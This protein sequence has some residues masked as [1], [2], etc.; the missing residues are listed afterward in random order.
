MCC[1]LKLGG[2]GLLISLLLGPCCPQNP[3]VQVTLAVAPTTIVELGGTATITATLSAAHNEDLTLHLEGQQTPPAAGPGY[4]LSTADI[5]VPA[6]QTSGTATVTGGTFPDNVVSLSVVFTITKISSPRCSWDVNIPANA[7]TIIHRGSLQ[8]TL[9]PAPAVADGAQWRVDG[10]AWQDSDAIVRHLTAGAHTVDYKALVDWVEPPSESVTITDGVLTQITRTYTPTLTVLIAPQ[11]AITGGAQWFLT[12]GPPG[13]DASNHNSGDAI[14]AP[15]GNYNVRFTA[16]AG[17]VTPADIPVTITDTPVTETGT[18]IPT[19]TVLIA[20]GT[21]ITG[22]AQWFLT[23]GPP[24]FDAS[25]HN[26]GDSIPAPAGDYTISFTDVAGFAK[27]SNITVT[28][29]DTPATETGTYTPLLT[30]LIQPGT[31]VTAGAQWFLTSGPPGFDPNPHNS[32]D[33]IPTPPGAYNIRFTNVLGFVAPADIPVTIT[34]TPDTETGTYIPTLTVFIEPQGA[35]DEG[36]QWFLT[37]GP[38]GFDTSMH[39]SGDTIPAPPGSYNIRFTDV[40]DFLTPVDIPVT[41]TNTPDTETG[42]YTQAP[43]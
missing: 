30:V 28:I 11:P 7:L 32:G 23:A 29:T 9:L 34:D 41:I 22:G 20:P 4:T 6:G 39:N 18:Y 27:P 1:G 35:I 38:V 24:G 19:L 5:V 37:S 43:S 25:N 16:V 10:G 14:P 12:A 13:F 3:P 36:A 31:A 21:A 15:P 2:I 42:V 26:S 33:S 8:V 17:F 40:L